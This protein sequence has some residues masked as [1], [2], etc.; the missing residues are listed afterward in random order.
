MIPRMFV[1]SMIAFLLGLLPRVGHTDTHY[2][3]FYA[4]NPVSPYTNWASASTSIQP[5][6][7]AAVNGA[8]VLVSNGVYNSGGL[9]QGTNSLTN[10]VVI[11]NSILLV[12]VS[13]NPADTV[14]EG[15]PDPLTTN[16][17][18]AVRCVRVTSAGVT[19]RGFTLRYGHTHTNDHV[20]NNQSGGAICADAEPVIANC[21]I[22][23]NS[24]NMYGGGLYYSKVYDSVI[25]YNTANNGGGIATVSMASNCF[26]YGNRGNG[27]GGGAWALTTLSTKL[28][29]CILSN[30]FGSAGG[31]TFKSLLVRCQVLNN[32]SGDGGGIADMAVASNC[33][34][35][36]NTATNNGGAAYASN[37]TRP[38]NLF[39]CLLVANS[40][41]GQNAAG[42]CN[43][44][45]RLHNCTV[46]SNVS[47]AGPGGLGVNTVATNSIVTGNTGAGGGVSNYSSSVFAHSCTYP[48][49]AGGQDAGGNTS[50]DPRFRAPTTGD[51][52]LHGASPCINAG[53]NA[54]WMNNATDLDGLVRIR[55][56][57]VD[58]GCYENIYQGTQISVR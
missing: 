51:Y 41:Q 38:A 4:T 34:F 32:R 5:A 16:G 31:G 26:L 49:P 6:L 18:A 8:V 46:V 9:T 53:T 56:V 35:K 7:D 15:A 44:V 36:G 48:L 25:C 40:S 20:N 42:A 45:V 33:V 13:T 2:V 29:D 27:S 43:G 54:V 19:I 47:A 10:R 55:Y 28:Y 30:N 58:M 39:N 24:A 22:A 3:D 17:P 37:G 12:A 57:R 52:R 14:I 23:S 21:V 11:S 50:A 1:G